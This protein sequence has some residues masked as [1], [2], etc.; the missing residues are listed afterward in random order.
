MYSEIVRTRSCLYYV[1]LNQPL[2]TRSEPR[3][4]LCGSPVTFNDTDPDA[5]VEVRPGSRFL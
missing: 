5:A 3:L 4:E 2:V 1:N